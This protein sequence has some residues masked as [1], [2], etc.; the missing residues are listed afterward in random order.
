VDG[1]NYED[2]LRIPLNEKSFFD[3][4]IWNA[5]V[6]GVE[7][8]KINDI[9]I[10]YQ[11]VLQNGK[12]EF[13]PKIEKIDDLNGFHGHIEINA[14]ESMVLTHDGQSIYLNYENDFVYI[15]NEKYSLKLPNS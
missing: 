11:E 3:I 10:Q 8:F 5:K 12:I 6:K 7:D 4:I 15:D 1:N 9:G 13:I 2:Y 14:Q